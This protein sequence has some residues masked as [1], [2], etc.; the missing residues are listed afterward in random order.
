MPK[1]MI[2]PRGKRPSRSATLVSTA[3]NN[4]LLKRGKKLNKPAAGSPRIMMPHSVPSFIPTKSPRSG[5]AVKNVGCP[6]NNKAIKIKKLLLEPKEI[7]I[8]KNGVVLQKIMVRRKTYFP[9]RREGIY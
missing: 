1:T 7:E 9:G 3:I 4:A 2:V 5:V 6:K 8:K